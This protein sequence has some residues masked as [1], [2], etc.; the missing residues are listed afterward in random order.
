MKKKLFLLSIG[1]LCMVLCGT[2]SLGGKALDGGASAWASSNDS[3]D[4]LGRVVAKG[5]I[6]VATEGTWSPWTFH[7]EKDRLVGFDVDVARK[8]AEK[9]GV[10]AVFVEGEWD[11]LLAGLAVGR[12]D[13]MAN[14]VEVTAERS[15]KYDFSQPYCYIRT[16]VIVRGDDDRIESMDDLKDMSTANTLAST[17]AQLAES[18]GAK[19]TGVDD[20]SQTIE[21]L[22]FRRVDATLNAEVTYYDYMAQHPDANLKIAFLSDQAS[23]VAFP[24]RK[25]EDSA[26]LRDVIDRALSDLDEEGV[27][28]ELSIRY[29]GKDITKRP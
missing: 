12:Y 20:L 23:H 17:Y 4:L 8:V 19:T 21:L 5:E 25:E 22:L 3:E 16:A 1:A 15:E 24:L 26:S 6:V 27:L 2:L 7:D 14:G 11:G 18:Y 28:S 10:K 9:L 29:F 13:T